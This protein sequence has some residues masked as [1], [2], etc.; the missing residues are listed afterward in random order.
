MPNTQF[1]RSQAEGRQAL[2]RF[3]TGFLAARI[4][5]WLYIIALN[6]T[7]L[8]QFE[9]A[10]AVGIVNA[11]R[12]LPVALVSVPSGVLADRHD[13]RLLLGIVN[14]ATALMTVLVAFSFH[15]HQSLLV[16]ALMVF[17]RELAAG[18]EPPARNVLLNEICPDELPRALASNASVLNVGRV[19]GPALAGY[20]LAHSHLWVVFGLAFLGLAACGLQT[21]MQVEKGALSRKTVSKGKAEMKEA[22]RFV[23]GHP[24]LKLLIALMLAPMV[25]GEPTHDEIRLVPM[26]LAF[27]YLSLLPMFGKEL[28]ACGPEAI[29]TLVSLTAVGSLVSSAT[30]IG[31][32]D[33]V[34]KGSFQVVTLLVFSASLL[35]VVLAPN[36]TVAAVAAFVAGASSQAYRTVSRIL[37]QMGVPK[38][39]QGRVVSL[40]LMD[41]ALIPVGTLLLGWWAEQFGLLSAGVLMSVGSG[42]ITLALLAWRPAIWTLS[43]ADGAE[44]LVQSG[45]VLAPGPA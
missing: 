12:L 39:L 18:M 22:L 4:G 38:H 36:F 6:W 41:R 31:S 40:I 8:V 13:S 29:G 20:L 1:A 44:D 33:R 37:A 34:L 26:V 24:R 43:P 35:V 2:N 5:E 25:L 19:V 23:A 15:T 28:L 11:C 17:G 45:R 27:P 32:S 42:V 3:H 14:L 16:V 21:L 10:T 9:S 30:I 7:V